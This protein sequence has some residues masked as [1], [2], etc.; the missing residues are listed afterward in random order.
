MSDTAALVINA[1]QVGKTGCRM[2]W[3]AVPLSGPPM[4]AVWRDEC[5]P[6]CTWEGCDMPAVKQRR[7][8]HNR[9]WANLCHGHDAELAAALQR[10]SAHVVTAWIRAQGGA[11]KAANNL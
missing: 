6:T 4:S 3:G 9:V 8:R 1:R 11:V 10:R 7:D 2:S 5:A